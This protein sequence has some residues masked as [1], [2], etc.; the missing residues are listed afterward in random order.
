MFKNLRELISTMPDEKTCRDYLAKERWNGVIICPYCQHD[1]CYVIEGGKRFKCASRECYQKFSVVTGTIMGASNLPVSKWLMAIY[2]LTSSKKGISS[3][4]LARQIGTSQQSGW[5]MLHRIR[6]MMKNRS[7]TL[8]S[9][10]IEADE[11]YLSRKYRS[12]YKGLPPQEIDYNMKNKIKNK[13]AV[14]GMAERGGEVRVKAMFDNNAKNVWQ[15]INE[16]VKP[17]SEL[18]TDESNLYKNDEQPYNRKHVTHYKRE[19]VKGNVHVNTVENFGS[20]MKRGVYGIY[21][22]IS[23]K[24]LQCYADEYSYRYNSRK[25]TDAERFTISLQNIEHRLTYNELIGKKINQ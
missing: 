17:V 11:T 5:F 22:H 20:V 4:Q 9:G 7:T 16:N 24:H 19:W 12:D 25:I 23:Y 15:A 18:H 2:L 14:I 21:H 6:L 8:L 13:G 1:K 10:I 3:Y